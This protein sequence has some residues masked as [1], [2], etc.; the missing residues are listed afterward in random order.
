MHMMLY[1]SNVYA[2]D[3]ETYLVS[4]FKPF[5]LNVVVL[6]MRQ[7]H[8]RQADTGRDATVAD[9][10]DAGEGRGRVLP[11]GPDTPPVHVGG[12]RRA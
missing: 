2:D 1:R 3:P 8:N 10:G 7:Q 12:R 5:V 6:A 9:D 11:V 4:A